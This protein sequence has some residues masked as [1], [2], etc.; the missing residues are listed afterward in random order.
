MRFSSDFLDE[1][2]D[3]VPISAVVGRRVTWDR[4]KTNVSRQDYWACCPFHGEKSPSFHCEDKK[5]RYHCFGCSVSGDHFKFLTELDGMSFP[6]AV[7]KIAE[8]AGVPMPVRDERE[9]RREKERASLTDVMEMA[10][11]FFQ[12]RLQSADG[13]K[14]RAYL[15]DRGLTPATQQSF[16]LGYAPDSRNA[17]KEHLAAKGVPKADI[18]ACGLVRHGDDIPVSYDWFRDRIMFPIPDS[19]GKIIAFGGRALQLHQVVAQIHDAVEVVDLAVGSWLV[20]RG[21]AVLGDIDSVEL[22][23]LCGQPWHPVGRLRR[24][25]EPVRQHVRKRSRNRQQVEARRS[26]VCDHVEL[27]RVNIEPDE[28]DR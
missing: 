18:E 5:G 19:R 25:P 13:A 4:K 16:R 12:E 28:V 2:R 27:W 7:E 9:E 3:R 20:G 23:D 8:M 14:A 26:I 17:L 6:E 10:T 11:A 1:I 15:R 21:G 24:D 22:P